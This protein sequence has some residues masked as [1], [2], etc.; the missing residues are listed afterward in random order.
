MLAVL[1]GES[2]LEGLNDITIDND[3]YI[4]VKRNIIGYELQ[5]TEINSAQK[6]CTLKLDKTDGYKWG[7]VFLEY[8]L[9]AQY[10]R[11]PHDAMHYDS[12]PGINC[13]R[14]ITVSFNEVILETLTPQIIIKRLLDHFGLELFL[15][16]AEK[17]WGGYKTDKHCSPNQKLHGILNNYFD[18]EKL[19]SNVILEQVNVILPLPISLLMDNEKFCFDNAAGSPLKI[20]INFRDSEQFITYTKH[21][22][23][24]KMS[25]KVSVIIE[26]L[27][28]NEVGNYFNNLPYVNPDKDYYFKNSYYTELNAKLMCSLNEFKLP[29]AMDITNQ[30]NVYVYDNLFEH[31]LLF[32]ST[33]LEATSNWIASL[34]SPFE[35]QRSSNMV[36]NLNTG[37]FENNEVDPTLQFNP[38]AC[39]QVTITQYTNNS[40]TLKWKKSSKF[41]NTLKITCDSRWKDIGSFYLDLNAYTTLMPSNSVCPQLF[42]LTSFNLKIVPFEQSEL[43]LKQKKQMFITSLS[44]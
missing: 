37:C 13:I 27:N 33:V 23:L 16:Y 10:A 30:L 7:N 38:K 31:Q 26:C 40:I 44:Y 25:T 9:P 41:S 6:S 42:H 21:T 36:I 11:K 19:E 34:F 20:N 15:E 1:Q 24:Q 22:I 28:P 39:S 32:G 17:W 35:T 43:N 14:S 5:S 12:L 18:A 3:V 8:I 2:T 4:P 29:I